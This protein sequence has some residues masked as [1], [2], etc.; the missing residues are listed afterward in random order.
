MPREVPR[1]KP[2]VFGG[3]RIGFLEH[4]VDSW[5]KERVRARS[6]MAAEMPEPAPDHPNI[7]SMREVERR[8]GVSRVCIWRWERDGKFPARIR[9]NDGAP[10]GRKVI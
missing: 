2:G 5:I 9:L 7:I 1:Q 3:S 6:G 4:E 8:I 10:A